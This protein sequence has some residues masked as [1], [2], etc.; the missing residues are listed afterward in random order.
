M[1]KINNLTITTLKGRI[2]F[3]SFSFVLNDGDKTALIGEEGNGKSTLLKILAG[4][5]VSDYVT[6]TGNITSDGLIGYLP[7][8]IN[9][10]E[11]VTV[12]EYILN[13]REINYSRLYDM[14]RITG[15]DSEMAEN[16]LLNT[17]SGGEKVRAAIARLMYDDP[18]ILLLD[19]PTN[20]LD[21][22]TLI[23]LE[24]FIR[25]TAKAILFISHDETL[26]RN[27]ADSILHVEQLK[28]K[29][30]SKVTF[31]SESYDDYYRRRIHNI[32]R[33]N[34]I[35]RKEK[36]ELNRQLERYRQIYQKVEYRMAT[37]SR[38]DPHGGQLLKKKMHS[39]KAQGR[40]FDEKEKNLT[41]KYEPEE[42]INVFFERLPSVNSSRII[43][44]LHLETLQIGDRILSGNID[45]HVRGADKICIIGRNGSGKSTLLKKI[46]EI[47]SEKKDISVG[48]M[49]QNY[50]E[51]LDY[52]MT[53][54]QYLTS[55]C[56]D[57]SRCQSLLGAMKY[58]TEEMEHLIDD[59]SEGQKCKLLLAGLILQKSEVLLLDEPTRNLSPLSNPEIR[60]ILNEYNGCIIAVSHDRQ[61]INE[62]CDHIYELDE[63]GLKLVE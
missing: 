4:N 31:S 20:D 26:L 40:R 6:Y 61:F 56:Q 5:D 9:A 2:L 49:P 17:L 34:Q 28:K 33:T 25:N 16:R 1:L 36:A 3:R 47:L 10:E 14:Y 27:C 11:N 60:R 45:L 35:A 62:V 41:E 51:V 37:I 55:I 38:G 50:R 39:L 63:D 21:L 46:S 43:L 12:L 54:V 8:Q 42:A 53:P 58:T 22:P 32:D 52:G 29:Q 18:D 44:D 24:E 59:L 30:E 7:Q 19:E 57:R 13:G 15:I 23:W 48:Y